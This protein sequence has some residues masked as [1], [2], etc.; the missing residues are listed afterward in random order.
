MLIGDEPGLGA[1]VV[2]G[3][4]ADDV[5]VGLETLLAEEITLRMEAC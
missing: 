4:F 2:L 3:R 5:C 1:A